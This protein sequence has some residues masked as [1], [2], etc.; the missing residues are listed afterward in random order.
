MIGGCKPDVSKNQ[1]CEES[2]H[3]YAVF[4]INGDEWVQWSVWIPLGRAKAF[5]KDTLSNT[6]GDFVILKRVS[7]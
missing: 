2:E 3:D 4:S 6:E 7:I 5:L 1:A